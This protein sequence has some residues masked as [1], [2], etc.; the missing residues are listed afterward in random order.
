[1]HIVLNLFT[2]VASGLVEGLCPGGALADSISDELKR[3]RQSAKN[4]SESMQTAWYESLKTL[5]T[6]LGGGSWTASKSRKQFAEKF[7]KEFITPFA[8]KNNLDGTKLDNFLKAGLH[9]CQDL[10]EIKDNIL[11]FNNFEETQL[12]EAL[13]N[14][15]ITENSD[16]MGI[17]II[18]R[19]QTNLPKARELLELLWYRNLLLEGLVAHFNFLLANNSSLADLVSH[20]DQQRIQKDLTEVKKQ[21]QDLLQKNNMI[22]ASKLGTRVTQLAHTNELYELQKNYQNLFGSLFTRLDNLSKDHVEINQKLDKALAMLN[23]LQEMQKA[24]MQSNTIRLENLQRPSPSEL[25]LAQE[26]TTTVKSIGWESLPD[27]K[28]TIAANSLVMSYYGS[29]KISQTLN[30]IEEVLRH[31]VES[32]EL[33]FNYF[34]VLQNV[35]RNKEAVN[36]YEQSISKKPELALFSS[37]KYKMIDILGRGGMGV[38]YKVE[39]LENKKL[40]AIKVLL[41]PEEWYAGARDRFIQAAKAA[42]S[43]QHPNIVKIFDFIDSPKTYS[44]VVMEYLEGFDLQKYVE[45]YGKLSEH[46]SIEIALKIAEGLLYAHN[47]GVIHRDL[48]PGNVVLSN[49]GP[50]IVDFGLAKWQKDSTLTIHG[51]NFYTLYY[52]APEQ[53]QDFHSADHRSDIYSLGKTLYYLLTG[54]EPYD[55]VW[56]D[57][58]LELRPILRKATR[59]QPSERYT[60]VQEIINDL[61]LA[62]KGECIEGFSC[63]EPDDF[64]SFPLIY[65]EPMHKKAVPTEIVAHLPAECVVKEKESGIIISQKD[66]SS[67]IV[68]PAGNFIMGDDSDRADF[69]ESPIHEVYLDAYLIDMHPVTNKQY[70]LFLDEIQKCNEHPTSWCHPDEPKNK[71][72]IPQFWYNHEWNQENHPVVGV[73]WWDAYAYSKWAGKDLP[74]EAEWEKAARGT[75]ARIYPW[76][77]ETPTPEICNFDNHYK[78]TTAIDKFPHSVSPYG[79]TNMAGNVWQWCSDWFDPLYYKTSPKNNPKGP[80]IG[81]C[82]VGRG[83]CW[84]NDARRIRTTTRGT[85]TGPSDRKNRLGFRTIKRLGQQEM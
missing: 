19:V 11:D 29:K 2:W 21:L 84:T 54:E 62:L 42:A 61:Q 81:K 43:L 37:T 53:R 10:L 79:C 24:R 15:N 82:H 70:R 51:E 23:E 18:D 56:E 55:V 38:V 33:Y 17:L 73:D 35:G 58:P 59:K 69:D 3:Y 34:Q 50:V 68:I 47:A 14:R 46:Q 27:A 28:R 12:L 76:G 31:G 75:D 71:S 4:I 66:N 72:H 22:E 20:L 65:A 36:A 85:G 44:C 57:I 77:N 83:G 74:T 32:P 39:C 45:K 49:R 67:M 60:S 64:D 8:V 80:N 25:T 5:E 26:L 1:M 9:Q 63:D 78:G 16:D 40:A 30:L 41:L 48:K 6:A 7:A 13:S 52:S